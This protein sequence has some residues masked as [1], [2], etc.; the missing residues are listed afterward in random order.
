M[1]RI[2]SRSYSVPTGSAKWYNNTLGDA[3]SYFSVSEVCSDVVGNWNG[4]NPFSLTRTSTLLW[5]LQGKARA[6]GLSWTYN[7]YCRAGSPGPHTAALTQEPTD[8]QALSE[9]LARTNPNRSVIDLP[10]FLFELREIPQLLRHFSELGFKKFKDRPL[11]EIGS[12]YLTWEYGIKPFTADLVRMMDFTNHTE[13]RLREL[14]NLQSGKGGLG[15]K[16][17]VWRDKAPFAP[18]TT[19]A[20]ALYSEGNMVSAIWHTEREKWVSTRWVPTTDL[21]TMTDDELRARA[22]R[23]VFGLDLSF[24]TLWEAMPWSWLIDWFSNV[25]D[26]M[27]QTRNTIPVKHDGSCVMRRTRTRLT[28]V[29]PVS[30]PGLGHFRANAGPYSVRTELLRTPMF[31][32]PMPEFN[33]PFLNGR[34]LSILSAIVVTRGR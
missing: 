28:S 18:W 21:S 12:N 3:P 34:Q 20:S 6:D 5:T 2:R 9:A 1:S 26:I 33:L 4:V 30:G 8:N 13:K 17:T 24:A 32:G 25:G 23:I 19:F 7:G 31:F 16:W 27:S 14:R 22:N 11:R 29:T 15:R 10:I